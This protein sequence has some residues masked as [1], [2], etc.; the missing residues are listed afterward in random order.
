MGDAFFKINSQGQIYGDK[1]RNSSKQQNIR[2]FLGI[3][4]TRAEAEARLIELNNL[5]N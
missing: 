2:D 1:W 3:F 5:K 4:E